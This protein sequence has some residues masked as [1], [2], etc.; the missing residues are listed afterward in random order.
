MRM[1][2]ILMLAASLAVAASVEASELLRVGRASVDITPAVGTPMLAPQRPGVAIKTAG[3]AHDPLRIKALV[4]E[5]GGRRVA[6]LVCDSIPSRG[7]M[8]PGSE[9]EASGDDF[10]DGAA[11]GPMA[12]R[13]PVG[14]VGEIEE[15]SPRRLGGQGRG[16]VEIADS[17][18][19]RRDSRP[20]PLGEVVEDP[21]RAGIAGGEGAIILVDAEL[22]RREGDQELRPVRRTGRAGL[23]EGRDDVVE[24]GSLLVSG[25]GAAVAEQEVR[26]PA[27]L[28]PEEA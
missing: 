28:L 24:G 18:A 13:R 3:V 4:L 7:R 26:R 22:L 21:A 20:E 11:G 14:V 9:R 12:F 2:R 23:G 1:I 16:Q 19:D 8:R 10:G 15:A 17:R 25:Q 6:I 27:I 5:E